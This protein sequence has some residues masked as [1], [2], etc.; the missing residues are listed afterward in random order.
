MLLMNKF[1]LYETIWFVS[2]WTLIHFTIWVYSLIRQLTMNCISIMLYS[3]RIIIIKLQFSEFIFISILLFNCCL[4]IYSSISCNRMLQL[5]NFLNLSILFIH[6]SFFCWNNT[7]FDT[8]NACF[9]C[10]FECFLNRFD[11]FSRF[12]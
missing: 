5:H 9:M 8:F 1:F 7:L 3:W 4:W 11:W 10:V 6:F 12:F 2:L